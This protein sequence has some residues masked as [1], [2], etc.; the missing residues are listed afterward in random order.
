MDGGMKYAV[1]REK[2]CD[3]WEPSLVLNHLNVDEFPYVPT[4]VLTSDGE[5]IYRCPPPIGFGRDEDW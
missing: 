2:A 1:K 4:G 5:M 3:D